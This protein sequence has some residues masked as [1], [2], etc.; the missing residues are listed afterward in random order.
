[1]GLLTE[2]VRAESESARIADELTMLQSADL[3][4]REGMSRYTQLAKN[5]DLWSKAQVNLCR[6]LRLTPHSQIGPKSAA[7]SSRR[8]GG[9]KPWDFTA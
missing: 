5:A 7:T 3:R 1:M 6:A 8:A 2:L 9:A 4:T